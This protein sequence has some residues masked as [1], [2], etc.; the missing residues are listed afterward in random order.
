MCGC[1]IFS[2]RKKTLKSN[3]FV[4]NFTLEFELGLYLSMLVSCKK[5]YC[6]E[7]IQDDNS[8]LRTTPR[9]IK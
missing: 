9:G 8:D 5:N 3:I 7:V 6:E 2:E 1:G 4:E